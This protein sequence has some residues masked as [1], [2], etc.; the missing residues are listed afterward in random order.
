EVQ[1][2][3]VVSEVPLGFKNV[4]SFLTLGVKYQ[5]TFENGGEFATT[6]SRSSKDS[7]HTYS[8]IR[9]EDL[10]ETSYYLRSHY[11][12]TFGEHNVKVGYNFRSIKADFKFDTQFGLCN[13]FDSWCVYTRFFAGERKRTFNQSEL[14]L[15][16]VFTIGSNVQLDLGL[17]LS[18]DHTLDQ[19]FLEPR[20]GVYWNVTHNT[21]VYARAGK[22]HQVP[23]RR[24]MLLFTP[25]VNS[26]SNVDRAK[27]QRNEK[28]QHA[29]VGFKYDISEK[30]YVQTE[31]YYKDIFTSSNLNTGLARQIDGEA[32]GLDFLLAKKD[33]GEGLYGWLA[34]S[35]G[36]TNRTDKETGE[37]VNYRY[38]TPLS[39]TL[40]LNYNF[41]GGWNFGTKLRVQSGDTYTPVDSI[42]LRPR[43]DPDVPNSIA[44][45]YNYTFGE[46]NSLRSP[47]YSRLDVRLEK[48]SEYSFGSVTY[49]VDIVNALGRENE[50]GR[51]FPARLITGDEVN[52]FQVHPETDT[53]IPFFAAFGVNIAF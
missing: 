1:D 12:Q 39:A 51:N 22:H 38:D 9:F 52:G 21:Q 13:N 30:W 36:K 2:E 29:F 45:R 6:I 34:V 24:E 27:D 33:L 23:P 19:T 50:S 4:S 20:V 42:E 10:K 44:N 16:D 28:A 40:A 26:T 7:L 11:S 49:Y 47:T 17:Q 3:G 5:K 43:L 32:Y 15:K 31:A 37:K 53:N 8:G 25:P 41:G 48:Q 46:P 35:Y 14:Y 18:K